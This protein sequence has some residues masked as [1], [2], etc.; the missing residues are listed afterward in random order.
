[1]SKRVW[2]RM[3]VIRMATAKE[4]RTARSIQAAAMMN[5]VRDAWIYRS[6]QDMN[7][8]RSSITQGEHCAE[9]FSKRRVWLYLGS[10]SGADVAV[11]A[12][13][14]ASDVCKWPGRAFN[15]LDERS[16]FAE[17]NATVLASNY[18]T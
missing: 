12:V 8:A 15:L 13:K 18:L 3:S 7:H 16:R 2:V 4:G 11:E 10:M 1:M 9:G 17:D 6:A 5:S 14:E